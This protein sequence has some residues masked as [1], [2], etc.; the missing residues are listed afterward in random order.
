MFLII[1]CDVVLK[2]QDLLR[3]GVRDVA[4]AYVHIYDIDVEEKK[5]PANLPWI[6]ASGGIVRQGHAIKRHRQLFVGAGVVY[7]EPQGGGRPA[8]KQ[9]REEDDDF[10]ESDEEDDL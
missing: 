5:A 4:E 10:E 3:I 6:K 9:R 7:V 1:V 2:H 8:K